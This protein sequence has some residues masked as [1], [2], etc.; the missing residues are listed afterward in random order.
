MLQYQ[1]E[2]SLEQLVGDV[3]FVSHLRGAGP[4]VVEAE[5]KTSAYISM[6]G[7]ARF[8]AG[9]AVSWLLQRA[10]AAGGC[11]GAVVGRAASQKQE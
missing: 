10:A 5:F 7:H 11:F 2:G 8:V 3:L 6:Y 9:R 1:G 4:T